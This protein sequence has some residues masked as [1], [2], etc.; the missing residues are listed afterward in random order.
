MTLYNTLYITAFKDIGRD[1]WKHFPR[2]TQEYMNAFFT[3]YDHC[4]NLIAFVDQASQ[5]HLRNHGGVDMTRVYDYEEDQNFWSSPYK[6]M[7]QEILQRP[8][9]R[10]TLTPEWE[11]T[12][13]M[14]H[15][16][17]NMV[18]HN[19]VYFLK[20]A[21]EMFPDYTYYVWIDFAYLRYAGA[22]VP[23]NL[24]GLPPG[25]S[26]HDQFLWGT[27]C[28]LL[29]GTSIFP[30][31]WSHLH[32]A[33][34]FGTLALCNV[35]TATG[36]KLCGRGCG[37]RSNRTTTR[38]SS[39]QAHVPHRPSGWMGVEFLKEWEAPPHVVA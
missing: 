32:C 36:D 39:A 3:L 20:R 2:T 16:E 30:V 8:A 1:H 7:E 35:Q 37:R 27:V 34:R 33:A 17:Y 28:M 29:T 24:Q 11:H 23:A 19:K 22:P 15:A 4:P 38:V 9:F 13:Q 5:A 26:L 10:A 25:Q 6:E 31:Y 18:N 14:N 21:Q 12:P